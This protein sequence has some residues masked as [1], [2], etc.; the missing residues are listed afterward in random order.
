MAK[1]SI[2]SRQNKRRKLFLKYY[3]KR[4]NLKKKKKYLELQKIP[5]NASIVRLKNLCK[6]TGRT[7]GYIRFFGISR[8]EFRK[9]SS[10][11]LIPGIKK[12]SW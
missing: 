7:R 9:L 8:I 11:G 6:I 4:N 12:A 10:N 5:K 2:K 1:E 3:K